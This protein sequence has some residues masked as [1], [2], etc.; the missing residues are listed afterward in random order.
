MRSGEDGIRPRDGMK[1]PL[2]AAMAAIALTLLVVL[3][4]L[5]QSNEGIVRYGGPPHPL[6]VAVFADVTDAQDGV[7]TIEVA[8]GGQLTTNDAAYILNG[9]DARNSFFDRSLYV[10]NQADAYNTILITSTLSGI[11]DGACARATVRNEFTG[12][13]VELWLAATREPP[14]ME[15]EP[16]RAS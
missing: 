6:I 14:S 3:P 12:A 11:A 9:A 7:P 16:T 8:T 1:A 13:A 10:S 4:V 5:A 2:L 15:R